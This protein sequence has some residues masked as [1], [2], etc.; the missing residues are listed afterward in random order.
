MITIN[1]AIT[2]D[3]ESILQLQYIAYESEAQIY[4]DFSI[5]PLTQTLDEKIEEHNKGIILKA[6]VDN[7]IIG[8]VRGYENGK[9]VYIGK[10]M[11]HPDHQGKGLGKQLLSAIERTFPHKR[12]ELFTGSMSER[13]LHLYESLG[14]VRFKEEPYE[15]GVLDVYLEKLYTGA[16]E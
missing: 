15:T 3:L 10:L 12:F 8:S 6:V 16:N 13:N 4:N 1:K 9:T 7:E 11:V 14:Y 2:E 5:Q